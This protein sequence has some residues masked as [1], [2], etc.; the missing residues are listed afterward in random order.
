MSGDIAQSCM[1]LA[2]LL[3]LSAFFSSSETAITTT[4]R[5]RLLALQEKHPQLKKFFQWV[6]YD[7][8]SVLTVVLISN[9]IVNIGA[10]ALTTAM[11]ISIAGPEGAFWAIGIMTVLIILFGEIFPKSIAIIY[12]E[13][14]V[15]FSLPL[16]W[17]LR[18][19]LAPLIWGFHKVVRFFG[20][21]FKIDL[22]PG[23]AFVTRKEIEQ[24]VQMGGVSGALEEDE[25]KMIHSIITFEETRAFEI[26]I[27]RTD[28]VALPKDTTVAEAVSIFE[29]NGH[30]RI[31]VF[32]GNLDN[33]TGTLHIKDL[34]KSL[35][36]GETEI[37][38]QELARESLFVPEVMKIAE[39]FEIMK[40]DRVHMAIVV[41]EYGGTAGLVTLED[42]LEEIVGEIQDEYDQEIPSIR[43]TE[44]G[45]YLVDG[46]VNLG[47][48]GEILED[49]FEAE[50][51]DSIAGLVLS[52]SGGFPAKGSSVRYG[53]WSIEVKEI[54]GHRIMQVALTKCDEEE[55]QEEEDL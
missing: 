2:V 6:V 25:R 27:P 38:V 47:D 40:D 29:E 51:V 9:N 43:Q 24:V 28:M 48:L 18:F 39:L 52:L 10:S 45:T 19:V 33:I 7:P 30:S 17:G 3:C 55:S 13:K 42:L 26:M 14:L 16:L 46:N 36:S 4:G 44:D 23:F 53:H 12:P 37:A 22:S 21:L 5:M 32:D 1:I 34:I 15:L 8:Q 49:V 31:P 35:S 11:A 54:L 20:T 50:D 41:D